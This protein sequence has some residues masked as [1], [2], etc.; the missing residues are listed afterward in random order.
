MRA[1]FA[2]IFS[3][4]TI[5]GF[6]FVQTIQGSGNQAGEISVVSNSRGYSAIIF[7]DVATSEIKVS[8][9]P[10]S[11][12]F[13]SA[14]IIGTGEDPK[15]AIDESGNVVAA[16]TEGGAVSYRYRTAG[17]NGSFGQKKSLTVPDLDSIGAMASSPSG[18]VLMFVVT[19]NGIVWSEKQAGASAN[20]SAVQT[21]DPEPTGLIETPFSECSIKF[22]PEENALVTYTNDPAFSQGLKLKYALKP[23]N[24][25]FNSLQSVS[26]P[27]GIFIAPTC[28]YNTNSSNYWFIGWAESTSLFGLT[29][30][31]EGSIHSG[32]KSFFQAAR[33]VPRGCMNK[34]SQNKM[35]LGFL[36]RRGSL[37]DPLVSATGILSLDNLDQGSFLTHNVFLD[38]SQIIMT[39]NARNG[40]GIFSFQSQLNEVTRELFFGWGFQSGN[41]IPSLRDMEIGNPLSINSPTAIDFTDPLKDDIFIVFT[42]E[43][44]GNTSVQVFYNTSLTSVFQQFGNVR[45]LKGLNVN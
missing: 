21:L 10:V 15:I 32:P 13:S 4:V 27:N 12:V 19:D 22:D 11:G 45:F 42:T 30:T 6:S 37:Q 1:L 36:Y 33:T 34:I 35:F 2:F 26:V 3:M 41:S 16:W 40:S 17:A 24:Q 43:F 8:Y 9:K 25:S 23:V 7:R 20:F 29:L 5:F 44:Q 38:D 14:V 31:K 18:R 39:N 28:F